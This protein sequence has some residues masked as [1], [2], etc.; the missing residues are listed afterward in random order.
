MR[1]YP[2]YIATKQDIINLLAIPEFRKQAQADMAKFLVV[3]DDKVTRT[4]SID[5][6]TNVAVTEVIDNPSPL[7]KVKGFETRKILSDLVSAEA[8]IDIVS[9]EKPIDIKPEVKP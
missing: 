2:K 3:T 6:L 5:A 4:I 9:D 7:Y 1:G 8:A